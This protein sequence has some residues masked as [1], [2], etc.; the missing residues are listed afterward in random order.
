MSR[1]YAD[2]ATIEARVRERTAELLRSNEALRDDLRASRQ[3]NLDLLRRFAKAAEG[4]QADRQ[5]RRAALNLMEDALQARRLAQH[6]NDE[7]RRVEEV[8]RQA[9]RRKDEFLAMLAHELRNP[10]APLVNSL[11]LLR[12]EDDLSPGAA[13]VR[14]VMERQVHHLVRIVDDLLDI[15]RI[16]RGKIELRRQAVDLQSIVAAAVETSRPQIDANHHQ[17]AITLPKERVIF[18]AD[19]VRLSQVFSNLLNNAAKYTPVGGQIWLTARRHQEAVVVS[20]RD[21]GVGIPPEMQDRVFD[22]FAQVEGSVDRAQGGLGIG[23]TL[24]KSFVELHDGTITAHSEGVN[25]GTEFVVTLPATPLRARNDVPAGDAPGPAKSY[26]IL[27]VDDS[28]AAADSLK[29]ILERLGQNVSAAYD[30]ATALELARRERPEIVISDIGMPKI[31]GYE[32]ARRL[33]S[34]PG[35]EEVVLVALTGYGQRQDV[36]Q[37]ISAGFNNHVLKPITLEGIKSLLNLVPA[38]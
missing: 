35:F 28:H 34:E 18:E 4:G 17:L 15:S 38:H 33:R 31:N 16:S 6:E 24:A 25:R 36:E 19:G 9:D 11:Q 10:L 20:V 14:E 2:S 22:M 27:V 23:L 1:N 30:A 7:R 12:L 3:E 13:H 21:T 37:A 8:L 26:R 32:F 5:S 29:R